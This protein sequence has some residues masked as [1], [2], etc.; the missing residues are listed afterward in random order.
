MVGDAGQKGLQKENTIAPEMAACFYINLGRRCLKRLSPLPKR[1]S[2]LPRKGCLNW[3]RELAAENGGK[4]RYQ[5]GTEQPEESVP[6]T[7]CLSGFR[8]KVEAIGRLTDL[9]LRDCRRGLFLGIALFP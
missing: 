2:P 7:Q 6:P 9:V 1:L 8:V 5:F 4:L 3:T